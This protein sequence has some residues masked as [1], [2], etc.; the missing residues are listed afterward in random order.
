M[1]NL[2][3][4]T[5]RSEFEVSEH[6][7]TERQFYQFYQKPYAN[8]YNSAQV[9]PAQ[10]APAQLAPVQAAPVHVEPVQTSPV[11][12]K[13]V[14]TAPVHAAPVHAAPVQAA[15][16]YAAPVQTNTEPVSAAGYYYGANPYQYHPYQQNPYQFYQPY[17]FNYWPYAAQPGWGWGRK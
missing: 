16:V 13:P 9:K 2:E 10:A 12:V 15:P 8:N 5:T 17:M 3:I 14:Q 7:Q 1:E 6:D 4:P 11:H